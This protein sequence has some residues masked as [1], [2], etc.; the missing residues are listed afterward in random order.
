MQAIV[1]E[2]VPPG[3]SDSAAL[4]EPEPEFELKR[5][6]ENAESQP[7][8]AWCAM[9]CQFSDRIGRSP[10]WVPVHSNIVGSMLGVRLEGA[11][12]TSSLD[13]CGVSLPKK[14]RP[15]HQY[16]LRID[17]HESSLNGHKKVVMSLDDHKTLESW[18]ESLKKASHRG[19]PPAYAITAS[20]ASG[21]TPPAVARQR[22]TL[23][24]N[25]EVAAAAM[26]KLGLNDKEMAPGTMVEVEGLGTGIYRSRTR[27]FG[28]N[29]HTI[30]FHSS[31]E[32]SVKLSEVNWKVVAVPGSINWDTSLPAGWR[33]FKLEPD[34][35]EF[36]VS[37]RVL[38]KGCLHWIATN[39]SRSPWVNPASASLVNVIW[40][41]VESN[42]GRSEIH[43][44]V[45]GPKPGL[46]SSTQ[47]RGGD[48]SE[49]S[50]DNQFMAVDL[51]ED[52]RMVVTNY[53][54]RHGGFGPWA[55]RNWRLEGSSQMNGP[56]TTLR[57][58]NNDKSLH[59]SAEMSVAAWTVGGSAAFRCFRIVQ[60]G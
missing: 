55:L 38:G 51:G 21:E 2:G 37:S 35:H 8:E 15:G 28:E 48:V 47:D 56:W 22:W 46:C 45:S 39:G 44:F 11:E 29:L 30:C 9:S 23:A 59:R 53:V 13:G 31:A 12:W 14:A 18:M 25:S 36:L 34:Y 60:I 19:S 57:E 50:E 54:L 49:R 3:T 24:A 40:S 41:S 16:C 33:R 42:F 27:Q 20:G 43:N 4:L 5:E 32:K 26:Q 58:H 7:T 6:L 10:P 1:P 52:R 17:L